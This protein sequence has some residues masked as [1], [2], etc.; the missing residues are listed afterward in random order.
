MEDGQHD[1]SLIVLDE[2][3]GVG[4]ASHDRAASGLVNP[5][6][7]LWRSQD[8]AEHSVYA[9][10]EA[11]PETGYAVFVPVVRIGHLR[12]G[13]RADDEPTTHLLLLMRSFT[14]AH[15]EP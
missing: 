9:E 10:Q 8:G 12:L 11:R 3:H 5:R 1:D 4:E 6:I 7:P 13:F 2:E 15:G 14:S